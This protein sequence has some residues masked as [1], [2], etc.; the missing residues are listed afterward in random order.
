M[1]DLHAHA[2][3]CCDRAHALGQHVKSLGIKPQVVIVSPLT[4]ALQTAAAA[5]GGGPIAGSNGNSSTSP[6]M[7]DFSAIP[8]SQEAHPPISSAGEPSQAVDT[9]MVYYHQQTYE[10]P[11]L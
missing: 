2:N 11:S 8:G 9:G 10:H 3:C 1:C 6:L 5:F 4:R 7:V